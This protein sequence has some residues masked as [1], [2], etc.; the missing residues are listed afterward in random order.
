[1]SECKGNGECLIQNDDCTYS[2]NGCCSPI[3]CPHCN[4]TI[5]RW[6]ADIKRGKCGKCDLQF[7]RH[8]LTDKIEECPVCLVEKKMIELKCDHLIC[9]D[10]WYTIT[11]YENEDYSDDDY[12]DE[13]EAYIEYYD[14]ATNRIVR[15]SITELNYERNLKCRCPLCRNK[16]SS[17]GQE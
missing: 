5:P 7:G 15:E 8:H 16:N 2:P 4:M 13:D 10:C 12:S 17:W 6:L 11:K 3:N 9:A 14:R 1:M